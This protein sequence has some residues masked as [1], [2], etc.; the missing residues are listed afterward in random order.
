MSY[1]GS[2]LATAFKGSARRS[3]SC[4][5]QTQANWSRC[6]CICLFTFISTLFFPHFTASDTPP[7]WSNGGKTNPPVEGSCQKR[8][9]QTGNTAAP[10]M[11]YSLGWSATSRAEGG[12]LFDLIWFI[13]FLNKATGGLGCSPS[14][15]EPFNQSHAVSHDLDPSGGVKPKRTMGPKCGTWTGFLE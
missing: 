7:R 3:D 4:H 14:E 13:L 15:H 9:T 1:F 8:S 10:R 11:K 12:L 5:I 2:L 6:C